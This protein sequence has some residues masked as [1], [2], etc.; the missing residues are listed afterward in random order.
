MHQCSDFTAICCMYFFPRPLWKAESLLHSHLIPHQSLSLIIYEC[1]LL[2]YSWLWNES[3]S[4]SSDSLWPHG[5]QCPWDSPDQNAGVSSCS[6]LQGIFPGQ[7]SNPGLP[8]C[9][10]ILYQLSYQGSPGTLEWGAYP[11]SGGPIPSRADL[12]DLLWQNQTRVPCTSGRFCTSWATR[13][14]HYLAQP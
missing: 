1:V 11:F 13:E 8:N 10:R 14:T 2:L 3:L 12:P 5:L 6:L 9:R 7:G 4:V